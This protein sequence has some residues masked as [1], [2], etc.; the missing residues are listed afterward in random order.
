MS[1]QAFKKL[2][3]NLK[4]KSMINYMSYLCLKFF[5]HVKLRPCKA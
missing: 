5:G 1:Y 3:L 4:N 2:D